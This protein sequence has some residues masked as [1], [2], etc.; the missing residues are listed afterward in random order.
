M[1]VYALAWFTQ[2]VLLA[3]HPL[4]PGVVLLYFGPETMMP[5][6]SFLAALLGLLLLFWRQTVSLARNGIRRVLVRRSGYTRFGRGEGERT[7]GQDEATD[8]TG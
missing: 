4:G 6:G 5:V 3:G 1:D 2:P 7:R 8:R